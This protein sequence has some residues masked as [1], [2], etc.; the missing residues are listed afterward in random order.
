MQLCIVLIF[1]FSSVI[2]SQNSGLVCDCPSSNDLSS[3]VT[4]QSELSDNLPIEKLF[5]GLLDFNATLGEAGLPFEIFAFQNSET[6]AFGLNLLSGK[7]GIVASPNV[8]SYDFNSA[9]PIQDLHFTLSNLDVF[10][11]VEI[12][13]YLDGSLLPLEA[14]TIESL[15]DQVLVNGNTISGI[16]T[17]VGADSNN[18]SVEVSINSPLDRFI[19]IAGKSVDI[20]DL[21][22]DFTLDNLCFCPGVECFTGDEENN[23]ICAFLDSNPNA[24]LASADCD[25]GGT[26]NGFECLNGGNPLVA[27][28]DPFVSSCEELICNG[29]LQI[30]LNTGCELKLTYDDLLEAAQPDNYQIKIFSQD[31]TFLRDDY[32]L[33]EDAGQTIKYEISCGGNS[34]WGEIIV[35]ANQLPFIDFPCGVREDG[36]VPSECRILCQPIGNVIGAFVTPEEILEIY[37]GCGPEILG[38]IKVTEETIG[39]ICDPF[40]Q[41]VEV[42]YSFKVLT[43]GKISVVELPKQRFT[44]I[45]LNVDDDTILFPE[46]ISLNCD[47]LDDIDFPEDAPEEAFV[48]GS[49]ESISLA[50]G[51]PQTAYLS[52]EDILD[53]VLQTVK[54]FDTLLVVV[55]KIPRDTM[56]KE[57]V[58]GIELWVLKTILEPVYEEQI[59]ERYDTI[60]ITNLIIPIEN[61]ACNVIVQHADVYFD[62]CGGQRILREWLAIDWCNQEL[63]S[64]RRQTIDIKD[65]SPPRAVEYVD[66]QQVIIDRLDDVFIG[67]EPWSCTGTFKL[68]EF[69]IVDDC[70]QTNSTTI[71]D[72]E[73][74][75]VKDGYLTN[76]RI[77]SEPIQVIARIE[78]EC[79][80]FSTVNFNV[81]VRDETPPISIC[82]SG[83]TVSL[84][85]N[86]I[87]SSTKVYAMDLSEGSHD[88]G[89]GKVTVSA[90]RLNDKR[91]VVRDCAGNLL[92]YAPSDCTA[93]T[94]EIKISA[95]GAKDDC[96]TEDQVYLVSAFGEYITVCCADIG[97]LVPILI[98]TVD[99]S[100]NSSECIVEVFVTDFTIPSFVCED[101]TIS[102]EDIGLTIQPELSTSQCARE[103]SYEATLLSSIGNFKCPGDVQI[104]EWYIDVDGSGDF[105]TGDPICQ[106]RLRI[107]TALLFDPYTIHWPAHV[108]GSATVGLNLECID[109][110]TIKT[111]QDYTIQME[112]PYECVVM[113]ESNTEPFWC[114]PDCGLVGT[115]VAIDTIKASDVCF[116]LIKRWTV[117][118]WCV[119]DANEN[120]QDDS[121][122][123]YEAVEDWTLN[124]CHDCSYEGAEPIYF[125][126]NQVRVDGYYTYD[127]IIK[128]VDAENP[129]IQVEDLVVV[130]VTGENTK[131]DDYLACSGESVV[132]ASGGDF[133]NDGTLNAANLRWTITVIANGS[134]IAQKTVHGTEASMNTQAGSTGSQYEII[135]NA[136][137]LCGNVASARTIVSFVEDSAPTPICVS[138]I[139]T[140]F[141]DET[142]SVEVWAK[143][144]DF[145]SFDNCTASDDL[146]FSLV[147]EGEEALQPTDFG[148][149]DQQY[150]QFNCARDTP[151]Q[152]L[153]VYVWDEQGNGDFCQIRLS[154]N[155]DHD[156]DEETVQGSALA[157]ISGFVVTQRNQMIDGVDVQIQS[158]AS[159]EY[160]KTSQTTA[161]GDFL[162][163]NNPMN[164]NYELSAE[165]VDDYINGLSTLDLVLI[166]RHIIGLENLTSPYDLI[167]SDVNGDNQISAS[168]LVSMR[169]LILGVT[170]EL[171][172]GKSWIFID[173]NQQFIDETSPWPFQESI[174]ILNLSG[175]MF[176]TDFMGIKLGDITGDVV[177]NTES[178][179]TRSNESQPLLVSDRFVEVGDKVDIS[180][181]APFLG[182]YFGGQ[183]TLEHQGLVF[184]SLA[185]DPFK[186]DKS[187]VHTVKDALSFSWHSP[188]MVKLNDKESLFT[189]SFTAM[190]SGLLSEMIQM[191]S[192]MTTAEV[193]MGSEL[194]TVIPYLDFK[195]RQD[196]DQ[197]VVLHQNYPNPFNVSTTIEF[198]LPSTLNVDPV[199]TIFDVDGKV[200]MTMRDQ[201]HPGKNSIAI[202]ASSL[203]GSGSY[204]YSIDYGAQSVARQLISSDR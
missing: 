89:C 55:N 188:T 108:D 153:D 1:C 101:K 145:G 115:T 110:G 159:L 200:V 18:F 44:T 46:D 57:I 34:C 6:G 35:E 137:D 163:G 2:N 90:I 47:Y 4:V 146:V 196:S 189:L 201:F 5:G 79:G 15:S 165:K 169:R 116:K 167:A 60:G 70:N 197:E 8:A 25:G 180:F 81:F 192:T 190:Q 139:T 17:S 174:S 111:I 109:D 63:N 160:P 67:L 182:E 104:N 58:G 125:R 68:P 155:A 195:A 143:D 26:N 156:C 175:D 136:K 119:Y 43:H 199:L 7:S 162:F 16:N 36:I 194:R 193:Y 184:E 186:L 112:G 117:V 13:S 64:G 107:D 49:P 142:G 114:V 185:S 33:E 122:D 177:L 99:K 54:V 149:G 134:T 28:D 20:N 128:V 157:Q 203:A 166:S 48:F 129:V 39:D 77:S 51:V 133:C 100:G 178:A 127:Q 103:V 151:E 113:D 52:Y 170:S 69:T 12:M 202:D 187:N 80:N 141:Y 78:D 168:D 41:I 86:S 85:G 204:F 29:N 50:S 183:F 40:G 176:D 24:A 118:D 42:G 56:V 147:R 37:S 3:S 82:E 66:G 154:I 179:R 130:S 102:H 75:I 14:I 98:Q 124:D 140:A 59:F 9:I 158:G 88:N 11:Q 132:T 161:S 83:L 74:G 27:D 138:G 94:K 173:G 65:N 171:P 87:S 148:F 97:Q 30:S 144:F 150:L 61:A 53:T 21:S 93:F 172:I 126:Y 45:R 32:L 62:A 76:L 96:T 95:S 91:D 191:N 135:W 31:G 72:G 19:L 164:F 71:W 198:D 22:V 10:D 120:D 131:G 123:L 84:T 106:Q 92:G 121:R 23:D 38:D 105:S 152:T 181:N 73:E